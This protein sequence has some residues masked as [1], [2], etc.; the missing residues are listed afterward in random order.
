MSIIYAP[1]QTIGVELKDLDPSFE[2]YQFVA[3]KFQ[4]GNASP[5][6]RIQVVCNKDLWN[7]YYQQ[8]IKLNNYHEKFV[9][10]GTRL[11]NPSLIYTQG[12]RVEKTKNGLYFAK[13]SSTSDTFAHHTVDCKQMFMCRILFPY[14]NGLENVYIIKNN[15]HH[16][17]QYLISY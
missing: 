9:F 16:Y 14:I 6:K 1:V 5:I 12:L 3:K 17:P 11:N 4:E 2:E 15:D 8:L 13:Y 10:H 7:N